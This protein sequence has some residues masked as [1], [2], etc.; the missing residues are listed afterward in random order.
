MIER[1]AFSTLAAAVLLVSARAVA[2]TPPQGCSGCTFSVLSSTP[3]INTEPG[4]SLFVTT[5]LQGGDGLCIPFNGDCI[6]DPC[7]FHAQIRVTGNCAGSINVQTGSGGVVFHQDYDE[8]Q[9]QAGQTYNWIGPIDC[10]STEAIRLT[11]SAVNGASSGRIYRMECSSCV[12]YWVS[13][14]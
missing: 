11:G 10:G 3:F 1:L 12:P 14:G 2:Q 7:V 8:D 4:C 9:I 6:P 5:R 13:P